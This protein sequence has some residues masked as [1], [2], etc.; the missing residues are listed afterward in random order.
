MAERGKPI[1]VKTRLEIKERKGEES[2]RATARGLKVSVNTVR[3][4]N[5]SLI[6]KPCN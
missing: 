2:L 3:K 4:Y 1:P 6:R 5:G